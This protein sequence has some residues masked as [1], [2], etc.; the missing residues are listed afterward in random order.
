[1]K[2]YVLKTCDTCRKALKE[3]RETGLEPHII[4]V[5]HDGIAVSDIA[6][7]HEVLGDQLINRRSTTWRGLS[8][9]ER[10]T[11]SVDLLA[12][13]PTLMKR[14]VIS[15]GGK[16]YLGWDAETRNSVLAP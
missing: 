13:F 3:I 16:L 7:F 4:D 9:T 2:I 10:A 14:P 15:V 6:L 11:D 8:E 12:R 1:M 5:R